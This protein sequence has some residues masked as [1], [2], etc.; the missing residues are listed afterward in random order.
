[1]SFLTEAAARRMALAPRVT[2]VQAPRYFSASARM[3]KTA[4]ETA[5]DVLKTVDRAVADKLVDGIDATTSAAE[6]ASRSDLGGKLKGAAEEIRGKTK[7][8]TEE[9]KGK[10]KGAAHEAAGKAKGAAN[11]M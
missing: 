5:K 9:F 4:T 7:G 6:K 1:M 2:I 3:H 8:S 11:R 10:A